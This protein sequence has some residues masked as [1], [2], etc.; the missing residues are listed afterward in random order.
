MAMSDPAAAEALKAADVLI[1]DGVGAVLASRIL[2]GGIRKRITGSDIFRELSRRLNDRGG[3]PG[4]PG[5]FMGG[6]DGAQAGEVDPSEQGQT[7]CK[8]HRRRGRRLRFL[9]G[10]REALPSLVSETRPGVAAEAPPGTAPSLATVLNLRPGLFLA[11]VQATAEIAT[12]A[13]RGGLSVTQKV[14]IPIKA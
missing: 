2:G 8:V 6:D 3:Q 1:P 7:E 11:C 13:P 4:R 12:H 5:R 10:K 14:S 9:R